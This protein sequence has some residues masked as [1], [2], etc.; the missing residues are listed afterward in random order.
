[1]IVEYTNGNAVV[2][3]LLDGTRTVTWVDNELKLDYPLN[4]DIRV[5]SGCPLGYNKN[6]GKSVCHFCHES[7]TVDG[8]EC[9]YTELKSVLAEIP[10][11]IEL[12]IGCNQ[13]SEQLWEFLHWAKECGFICNLTVNQ[14]TIASMRKH[15]QHLIDNQLIYG[16]GVSF[17]AITAFIPFTEYDN[18]VVHVIAG[19]DDFSAVKG[20]STIGVKKIL[21]L[22]EKD[23]G[24]NLG[25]VDLT[26][27]SHKQWLWYVNEL[28]KL[29][30]VVAF[31]N[32]ALEQLK[33][34]RFIPDDLWKSSYQHE[35]SFYI[36]AVDKYFSPSS[37]NE[38]KSNYQSIKNYYEKNISN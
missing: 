27:R 16:L 23:F 32:L 7:A 10:A 30:D 34:K 26:S 12:A 18:M 33:I 14:L 11:G 25:K 4:I 22:G 31:D 17:R 24:F 35:H 28:F 19:I 20:L 8:D 36:N 29:F 5:Q 38:H 3:V 15:I 6:T 9:D 1:M 13:Y 2:S 37:R 21:I